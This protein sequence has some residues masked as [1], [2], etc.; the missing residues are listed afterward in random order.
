MAHIVRVEK[1]QLNVESFGSRHLSFSMSY[2][3]SYYYDDVCSVRP[4]SFF[5]RELRQQVAL[6]STAFITSRTEQSY[7]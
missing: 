1:T 7:V 6:V 4:R 3:I 5:V 2:S